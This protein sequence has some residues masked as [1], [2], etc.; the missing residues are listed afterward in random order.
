M[1]LWAFAPA[2]FMISSVL[3]RN[4]D[5]RGFWGGVA[6]VSLYLMPVVLYA[7]SV[8]VLRTYGTGRPTAMAALTGIP[9][10]V[11]MCVANLA[12]AFAGCGIFYR[13]FPGDYTL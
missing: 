6:M 9:L 3:G 13:V 10:S 4:E 7:W 8:V 2:L 1:T 12:V 5:G 11:A